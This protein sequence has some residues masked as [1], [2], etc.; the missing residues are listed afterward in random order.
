[1]LMGTASP[2]YRGLAINYLGMRGY[3]FIHDSLRKDGLLNTQ[4]RGIILGLNGLAVDG[5]RR[6][7]IHPKLVCEGYGSEEANPNISCLLVIQDRLHGGNVTVR[8]EALIVE[9][10]LTESCIPGLS[11]GPEIRCRDSE[12]PRRDPA[13]PICLIYEA[14]PHSP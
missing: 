13:D 9:A 12:I 2:S 1:M 7:T 6:I 8:M 3:A 11:I 4:H 10:T 14:P 5:K